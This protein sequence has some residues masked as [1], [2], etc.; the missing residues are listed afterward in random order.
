ME[1]VDILIKYFNIYKYFLNKDNKVKDKKY[2]DDFL[3]LLDNINKKEKYSYIDN[4]D[5]LCEIINNINISNYI[6]EIN[7]FENDQNVVKNIEKGI[8]YVLYDI[9]FNINRVNLYLMNNRVKSIDIPL[10]TDI[11]FEDLDLNI[12]NVLD[13]LEIKDG[14]LDQNLLSDLNN[15][16]NFNVFK[17]L[18]VDIKTDNGMKRVLFDKIEDKNVLV[19]ILLH[20]NS[21]IIN[22]VIN[23]FVDENTNINKVVSNIPSIF[24]KDLISSKCK[25]N[26][27]VCD[28]DNFINNY[29]LI[30]E[31]NL[32]FKKMLNF[33]F[34]FVNDVEKNKRIINNIEKMVG[35][36]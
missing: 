7:T 15:F 10:N 6:Q 9:M 30:K 28:Y 27:V 25:Y 20:S 17:D 23:K 2:I 32:N 34:F 8:D 11:N 18:A 5:K 26:V 36:N 3:N 12:K 13:Y 31:N 22:S 1:S 14:E 16:S 19:S 29:N 35:E 4:L 33:P 24:I 21:E